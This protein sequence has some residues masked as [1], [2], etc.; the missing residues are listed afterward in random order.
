EIVEQ[1]NALTTANPQVD[2]LVMENVP[3]SLDDEANL[4]AA[5]LVRE[6]N[7][8]T[9]IP[10]RGMVASGGTDFFLAGVERVIAPGALIGVHS[11]ADSQG[12]NGGDLPTDHSAHNLYLE[13]YQSIGVSPDFYWYT[14]AAAPAD[15]IH[16]MTQSQMVQYNMAT[17]QITASEQAEVINIPAHFEQP[18]KD[19]FDRYTWLSAPNGKV[20]NIFAQPQVSLAQLLRAKN[21]LK[22]YLT[23]TP[24]LNKTA[25]ANSMGDKNASLFIFKDQQS[26]EQAFNGALGSTAPAQSGQD[27]YATEIF[28]EGDSRYLAAQPNGRDATM[29]EVLHLTQAYGIAPAMNGLQTQ[30]ANQAEV[31]LTNNIWNPQADQLA[32]WRAEGTPASGNSVSHEY[33]AAIVEAYFGLWQNQNVGMDG[34]TGNN[35][36]LQTQRDAAGQNLVS[37]FV[38]P[39]ITPMME[40]DASFGAGDTFVMAYD[41]ALSYTAKSQY[42]LSI[43]LNGSNASHISAN[44]ADNTL[45]GNTGNNHIDGKEGHDIYVVD[46]LKAE[47]TLI[48]TANG[49]LLEDTLSARNGKDT[50]VN[51]EQIMFNDMLF[52]L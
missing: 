8:N 22:F 50:L 19:L 49:W 12:N 40:I 17:R 38:P 7:L 13:F 30:L 31:A 21:T 32:E 28:V 39:M 1:L 35:R 14:L 9:L 51:I 24:T 44:A 42:L 41:A 3:G 15:G 26:S 52:T 18:I 2:T 36:D 6:K 25:L 29:E 20:I 16:W 47:F 10:E 34:Y 37:G 33:F 23:D 5:V 48:E 43:R 4:K 11:W 46:G 27:L 45:M